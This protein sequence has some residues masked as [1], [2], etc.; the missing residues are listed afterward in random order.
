MTNTIITKWPLNNRVRISKTCWEYI[1][2]RNRSTAIPS[3]SFV[4]LTYGLMK[5]CIIG[6]I[7]MTFPPDFEVNVTFD[8]GVILQMQDHWIE[9]ATEDVV[10]NYR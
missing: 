8:N 4:T 10:E 2:N 1:R 6:T 9:Q 7:T 5:N 3:D